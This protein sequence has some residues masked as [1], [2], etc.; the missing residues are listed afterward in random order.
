MSSIDYKKLVA[1]LPAP[2]TKEEQYIYALVCSVAEVDNVNK[3]SNSP[4]WRLEQYWRAFYAV[5]DA[6]LG[7]FLS[8]IPKEGE[9]DNA[10]IQNSSISTNKL[11]PQV[12]ARLLGNKR[13]TEAMLVD[14]LA[15]KLLSSGR[16]T[17]DMLVKA[18]TDRLL[19]D[20]RITTSMLQNGCVTE[21]K[22]SSDVKE[23]LN[24]KGLVI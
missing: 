15:E 5:M 9:V 23:K 17:E 6:R 22:L 12:E 18:I 10:A 3:L 4:F 24:K 7:A 13:V 14:A 19:G 16:I 21:D 11:T 1:E 20:N 8:T 2:Q